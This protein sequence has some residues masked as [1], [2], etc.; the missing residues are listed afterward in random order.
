MKIN[1][2][3]RSTVWIRFTNMMLNKEANKNKCT[4][5]DFVDIKCRKQNASVGIRVRVG[6]TLGGEGVAQVAF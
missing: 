2:R 4:L 6:L 1:G 5:Y 3:L